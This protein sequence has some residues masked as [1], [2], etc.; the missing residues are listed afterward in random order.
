MPA[1][2]ALYL[3]LVSEPVRVVS[4][5]VDHDGTEADQPCAEP[6]ETIIAAP[7]LDQ[8][9]R[10]PHQPAAHP[11]CLGV[12]VILEVDQIFVREPGQCRCEPVASLDRIGGFLR[13]PR[14]ERPESGKIHVPHHV[15]RDARSSSERRAAS[16]R[17]H[18]RDLGGG[19]RHVSRG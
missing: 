17:L 11:I 10:V 6:A 14:N 16:T 13:R 1:G 19:R 7:T 2:Q 12:E 3:W 9:G 5:T 15:V 18:Q 8:A 4:N